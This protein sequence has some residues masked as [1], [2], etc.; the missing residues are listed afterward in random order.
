MMTAIPFHCV[1][2]HIF[3]G[4]FILTRVPPPSL[5]SA[6]YSSILIHPL[7]P[8]DSPTPSTARSPEAMRQAG[9]MEEIVVVDPGRRRFFRARRH[10]RVWGLFSRMSSPVT[11]PRPTSTSAPTGPLVH[12]CPRGVSERSDF[13][14]FPASRALLSVAA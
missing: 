2:C 12:V 9:L 3:L 4:H 13:P 11:M 14:S 10:V 5:P 8:P 1:P 6:Q 7:G